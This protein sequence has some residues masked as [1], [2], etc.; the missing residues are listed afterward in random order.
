[1]LRTR[2]QTAIVLVA[3]LLLV[4]FAMP[5]GAAIGFLGALV[6]VGAWEWAAFAGLQTPESRLSYVV[7]VAGLC[8]WLWDAASRPLDLV[9]A[10][11]IVM[12]WW[13]VAFLWLAF[14][15][16]SI[17]RVTAGIA[18]IF[19]LVPAWTGLA[20]LYSELEQGPALV[21]FVLVLVWAADVG[22]YFAGRRFGRLKLA[23]HVSPNKTWEGLIGGVAG[24]LLVAVVGAWWFE[25]A[26]APFVFLCGAVVLIS[27]VGDLTESMFKRHAGLKDSGSVLP[28]HGGVLDRIDSLTAA[29]PLFLIGL[30]WLGGFG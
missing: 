17:T 5:R 13:I 25:F 20:R 18:G 15:S 14:R 29:V 3:L 28:G 26:L 9:F 19:V 2:I 12:V 23:P 22:A 30:H 11:K 24:G 10:L 6:L 21:L 27:I 16:T 1:M 4:L 7:L 8:T